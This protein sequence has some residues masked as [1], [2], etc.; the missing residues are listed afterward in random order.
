MGPFPLLY[1]LEPGVTSG[2]PE[3]SP[4]ASAEDVGMNESRSERLASVGAMLGNPVRAAILDVL[5]DGRERTATGLAAATGTLPQTASA[6]LSA[7]LDAGMIQVRPDGRQRWFV[8]AGPEVAQLVEV[9]LAL[10][11]PPAKKPAPEFRLARTCY[12][13]LAGKLGIAVANS[14]QARGALVLT[15]RDFTVTDEGG[16]F[17]SSVG[18][19]IPSPETKRK[20]AFACTDYTERQPHVAGALGASIASAFFANGWVRRVGERRTIE[21]TDRGRGAVQQFFV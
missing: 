8:L 21:L 11:G 16:R 12:D 15:D 9:A 2:E 5:L 1:R 4:Q 3:A 10:P 14:L 6:H 19:A 20:Y 17:L 7:L 18:I 13:H